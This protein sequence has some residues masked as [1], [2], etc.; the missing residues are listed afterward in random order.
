MNRKIVS[1]LAVALTMAAAL[2]VSS[3]AAARTIRVDVGSGNYDTNGQAWNNF[4]QPLAGA[5][6]LSGTLPFSINFGQGSINSFCLFSNGSI[7]FSSNCG[8]VPANALLQPLF[9]N[10]QQDPA[11]SRLFD[12]GAITYSFGH[13]APDPPF[14]ADPNDAPLA[15]RFHWQN[16]TCDTCAGFRYTFQAILIDM[17]NG[18]FDLELNYGNIPAGVGI[19]GFTLGSNTFSLAGPFDDS[20]PTFHFRG[21]QLVG[22][23]PVPEP[24]TLALVGIALLAGFAGLRKR[25]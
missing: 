22:V 16:L 11:A 20:L 18:D 8:A 24:S 4:E 3:L 7:G 12:D 9:A 21:G 5:P 1:V 10:W 19:A 13:L 6:S 23:T 14:P 17:G 2:A 15:A 25:A